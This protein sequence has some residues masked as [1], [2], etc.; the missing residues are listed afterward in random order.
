M[1][2]AK[3]YY[4]VVQQL[5]VS[6]F[7]RPADFRGLNDFAAQLQARGAP[8]DF[9]ALT[10]LVQKSD[11][12][13]PIARLINSFGSSSES[14]ALYGT[15]NTPYGLSKFV[16]AIYRNVLNRSPDPDGLN[17]WVTELIEGRLSK[18]YAAM[19][20]TEG[21]LA[22]TSA[23]G[24]R[25]AIA[26]QNKLSVSTIFTTALDTDSEIA[27]Y[28]GQPAATYMRALLKQVT[29]R[30]YVPGFYTK[31]RNAITD[32]LEMGGFDPAVAGLAGA[33][34]DTVQAAHLDHAGWDDPGVTLTGVPDWH[35]PPLG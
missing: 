13:S 29:D 21:A 3:D 28:S 11:A 5:Y 2:A 15:D 33:S 24:L 6:Y 17:Y 20:I 14:E 1:M 9:T 4:G 25:D 27:A 12:M 18:P 23:Q 8:T 10:T 31:I 26:V 34:H 35:L 22:N 19:A 7:G 32:L 30:T 16:T